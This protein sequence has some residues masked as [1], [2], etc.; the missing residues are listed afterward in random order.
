MQEPERESGDDAAA[1]AEVGEV[2][3]RRL[4]RHL[5]P[6]G[7]RVLRDAVTEVAQR[8]AEDDADGDTLTG[9]RRPGAP[10]GDA[11]CAE[12]GQGGDDKRALG[13]ETEG[14]TLVALTDAAA[15]GHRGQPKKDLRIRSGTPTLSC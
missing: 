6:V 4:P 11:G 5:H 3:G 14:S 1:D 9:T 10:P 8:A 12:D 13:A 7:D 15:R 2:E